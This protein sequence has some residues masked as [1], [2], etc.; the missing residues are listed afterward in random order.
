[1]RP[2]P[3]PVKKWVYAINPVADTICI[4]GVCQHKN[5]PR[6]ILCSDKRVESDF[7]GTDTVSKFRHIGDGWWAAMSGGTGSAQLLSDLYRFTLGEK[8]AKLTVS[9]VEAKLLRCAQIRKRQLAN[10]LSYSRFGISYNYILKH[11]KEQFPEDIL[12]QFMLDVQQIGLGCDLIIT[13][14][15]EGS[16]RL[17]YVGHDATVMPIE[18]S[19]CVG[20]GYTLASAALNERRYSKHMDLFEAL[21]YVYEAKRFSES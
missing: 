12:K 8:T 9:Q 3:Q 11:G 19:L 4:A 14:M 13:G 2:H 1:L 6:V 18:G 16:P 21:Y 17:Y 15:L 20:S 5:E 10:E 7:S